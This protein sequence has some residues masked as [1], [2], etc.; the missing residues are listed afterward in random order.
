MIA[1]SG[2]AF[3][4]CI[5]NLGDSFVVED[6]KLAGGAEVNGDAAAQ[7]ESFEMGD[8]EHIHSI[9]SVRVAFGDP[10]G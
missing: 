8:L 10:W 4:F 5:Q 9:C 6:G 1:R 2:G 3:S 7:D